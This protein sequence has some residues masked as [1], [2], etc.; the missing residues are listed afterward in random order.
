MNDNSELIK[1]TAQFGIHLEGES[2]IDA[3]LLSKTISD[4]AELTQLAARKENPDAYL[5]M[6]V[7]AFKNGSFQID[8]STVC[9]EMCIRDRRKVFAHLL[10]ASHSR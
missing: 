10:P 6:N 8:F 5:K 7:T 4:M 2:E 3:I 9:E 1:S